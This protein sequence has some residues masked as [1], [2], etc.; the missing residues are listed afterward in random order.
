MLTLTILRYAS[1]DDDSP[2]ASLRLT[3]IL[4]SKSSPSRENRSC[5]F[6]CNVNIMSAGIF[7]ENKIF[8]VTT[9]HHHHHHHHYHHNINFVNT[10]NVIIKEMKSSQLFIIVIRFSSSSSGKLTS[11][12]Y[13]LLCRV[14]SQKE[15]D[16]M[17][18]LF[19]IITEDSDARRSDSG[20]LIPQIG[21]QCPTIGLHCIRQAESHS[22]GHR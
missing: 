21:W 13:L 8:P 10:E 5:G 1:D 11:Y 4:C 12:S 22:L 3:F 7:P 2:K 6:V 19:Q 15:C 17:S 14:Y 16:L 18:K 20:A 9:R